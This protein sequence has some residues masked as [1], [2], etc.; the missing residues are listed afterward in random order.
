[1]SPGGRRE[2]DEPGCADPEVLVRRQVDALNRRDLDG[3]VAFYAADA[4]LEMATGGPIVGREAIRRAYERYMQEWNDQVTLMRVR[5]SGATVSAEG[6]ATGRHR[7]PRLNIPGRIPVPLHPYRH[8]FRA[9]WEIRGGQIR[10]H[11]VEYDPVE[12]V[13][14]L[15]D[16]DGSSRAAR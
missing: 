8:A 7:A 13:R 12:L 11:R 3:L 1:V 15:L 9:T 5:V 16:I 10:R 14:Q 6:I 2:A 4:V